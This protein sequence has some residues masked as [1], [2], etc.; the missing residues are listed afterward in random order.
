MIL[1]FNLCIHLLW[2]F[3]RNKKVGPKNFVA[4]FWRLPY[5]KGPREQQET[6][7]FLVCSVYQQSQHLQNT[8]N[9]FRTT[10]VDFLNSVL[11]T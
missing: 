8:Q 4:L 1:N 7:L 2:L 11:L 6:M 9:Y 3:S 5:I 10:K